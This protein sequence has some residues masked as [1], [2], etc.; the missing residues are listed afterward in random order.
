MKTI[1]RQNEI[2]D[3]NMQILKHKASNEIFKI[4]FKAKQEEQVK[5]L[6]DENN[7]SKN[8]GGA[9][10]ARKGFDRSQYH[11]DSSKPTDNT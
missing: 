7:K 4:L 9:V 5:G 3:K 11:N 1:L 2:R 8:E 6:I 10:C